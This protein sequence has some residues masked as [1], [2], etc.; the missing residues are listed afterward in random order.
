MKKVLNIILILITAFIL[1]L[2]VR[3]L[4]GIPDSKEI[5]SDKWVEDGPFELSPE[6]GRF[7]LLYSIVEDKSVSFS[8][9]IARF[10]T[11][12]LGYIDGKYVSLFAPAVSFISIPGYL[13][14]KAMGI[15][16]VGA[17]ATA[18]FFAL[19]NVVLIRLIAKRLGAKEL[20]AIIAAMI[21]LF[22]TPAF[23]YAVT[24]YQHHLSTFFILSS[25]FILLKYSDW[26]SHF[27]V[28]FLYA[29]AISVDYP[30]AFLMLPVMIY[31]LARIFKVRTKGERTKFS[32]NI[33][34][35]TAVVGVILPL[36]FFFWFHD[37]SYGSPFRL[38][39]TVDG[40]AEV[41]ST[42]APILG[43]TLVLPEIDNPLKAVEEKSA[44]G[45]FKTRKLINGLYIHLISPD[46]GILV[47][48][49]VILFG[50][51][52]M[53]LAYSKKKEL[54]LFVSIAGV[55]L[56]LY[57]LWI[58]PWGGWAFGSRYL[59]PSYAM[60]AVFIPFALAKYRKHKLFMVIFYLVLAYSLA[61]NTLGAVTSSSNPPKIEAQ[62]LSIRYEKQ[63]KY[64]YERN[65]DM[66]FKNKSKSYVFGLLKDSGV[67]AL[68]YYVF[69]ST[70]VLFVVIA[71]T[72]YF[73]KLED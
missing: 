56:L 16:Q 32:I 54:P 31:S 42:G 73:Y 4:P 40:V 63:E 33:G 28:W 7:A 11:P 57:S 27:I 22:A 49:P 52:G 1:I 8:D 60:L 29:L 10:T 58:D 36:I 45:F 2:S 17:F 24:L 50:L 18:S 41:T 67:S 70:L 25:V 35:L 59:I 64:T 12:D 5:N 14:G 46:R 72:V 71:P 20:P 30:N 6:R 39:G 21:F 48:A 62:A 55:N 37:A 65:W 38:S 43:K 9:D 69:L 61:V 3:G 26:K 19:L 13:I 53:K 47:Y 51:L 23:S 68:S 66:L 34:K 15:S 44:L